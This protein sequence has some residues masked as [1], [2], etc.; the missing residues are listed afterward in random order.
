LI[1]ELGLSQQFPVATGRV[2]G[3]LRTFR[4]FIRVAANRRPADLL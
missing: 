4:S 2:T 3:F 1:G